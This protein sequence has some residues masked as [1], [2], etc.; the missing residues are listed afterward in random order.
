VDVFQEPLVQ[1]AHGMFFEGFGIG[2]SFVLWTGAWATPGIIHFLHPQVP[3]INC[4]K[5][6]KLRKEFMIEM[7]FRNK[8]ISFFVIVLGPN[9]HKITSA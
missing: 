9:P 4:K 3:R 1:D 7:L 6:F 8:E 5:V 2:F